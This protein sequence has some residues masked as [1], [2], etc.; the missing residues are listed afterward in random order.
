MSS[1]C[2]VVFIMTVANCF[3]DNLFFLLL[4]ASYDGDHEQ[5]G[6]GG[7]G[8]RPRRRRRPPCSPPH[9]LVS[10]SPLEDLRASGLCIYTAP[11]A[12]A[13]ILA[14][15]P[16]RR[17]R[18]RLRRRR[19]RPRRQWVHR[20]QGVRPPRVGRSPVAGIRKGGGWFRARLHPLGPWVR[21]GSVLGKRSIPPF[22]PSLLFPFLPPLLCSTLPLSSNPSP[23]PS[24][25]KFSSRVA[26]AH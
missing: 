10:E 26:L 9:S 6:G 15:R 24:A 1:L 21:G 18:P 19:R 3:P 13:H 4:T 7:G 5:G 16:L 22:P 12:H 20:G 25:V 23:P 14:H 2:S 8:G 17:R 11:T